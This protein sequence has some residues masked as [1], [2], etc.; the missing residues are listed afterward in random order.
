MSK[1]FGRYAAR[2]F[3]T[4]TQLREI[5]EK[6]SMIPRFACSPIHPLAAAAVSLYTAGVQ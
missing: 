2:S 1:V 3:S 4:S 5:A 6:I